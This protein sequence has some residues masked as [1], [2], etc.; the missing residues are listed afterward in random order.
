MFVATIVLRGLAVMSGL[1]SVGCLIWACYVRTLY[2]PER[3]G[4]YAHALEL[5]AFWVAATLLTGAA[6][7]VLSLVTDWIDQ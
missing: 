6:F 3:Y 5:S 2:D 4:Q 1:G 7:F